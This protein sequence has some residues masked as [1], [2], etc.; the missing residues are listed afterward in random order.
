MTVED[1][2]KYV[3]AEEFTDKKLE[4]TYVII[5]SFQSSPIL[6]QGLETEV[7]QL[8]EFQ[9]F[10]KGIKIVKSLAAQESKSIALQEV[11][12]YLDLA[13]FKN[14]DS[15]IVQMAF[16]KLAKRVSNHHIV[17]EILQEEIA[18]ERKGR[19]HYQQLSD[20][21][22]Q[23]MDKANEHLNAIA[24]GTNEKCDKTLKTLVI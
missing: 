17:Q 23:E 12:N 5:S 4:E 7:A 8:E 21:F 6:N 14:F 24:D 1:I 9:S 11:L 2:I 13:N 19:V 16:M 18:K 10:E 20:H 22:K 15:P 3:R